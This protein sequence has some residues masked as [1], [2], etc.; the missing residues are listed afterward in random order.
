MT[1]TAGSTGY[2]PAGPAALGSVAADSARDDRALSDA[3]RR[4]TLHAALADPARVR[5]SDLLAIGDHSPTEL[6][7]AL[8]MPSNLLAHHLK[9]LAAA[10]IVH[11]QRSEA[12]RRR[13]YWTLDADALAQLL[14]RAARATERIVFLCTRNSA[15][16]QLA[17]ALWTQHS[18]IPATSAGT[19]PAPAIHPGTLAAAERHH[20]PLRPQQ[21]Q[22]LDLA[23]GDTLIAVCDNAHEELDASVPRAHWSIPDPVRTGTDGDFDTAIAEL[24]TRIARIAPHYRPATRST[25]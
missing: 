22:R 8:G 12:D 23:D 5:I 6:Q 9:T 13:A 24:A 18:T 10:G 25:P 16:S 11:K 17:A 1:T 7:R 4:A 3:H 15:R 2:G 21:P 20:I 14:P 19:R